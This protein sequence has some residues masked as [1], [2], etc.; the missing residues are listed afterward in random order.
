M[1]TEFVKKSE[2]CIFVYEQKDVIGVGAFSKRISLKNIRACEIP[3]DVF[4]YM[5]DEDRFLFVDDVCHT[6]EGTIVYS[7]NGNEVRE[8]STLVFDPN[9][10]VYVVDKYIVTPEA[11]KAQGEFK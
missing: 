1:K 6:L 9:Y 10:D 4:L 7:E 3:V 11:L 8:E 5:P 2:A